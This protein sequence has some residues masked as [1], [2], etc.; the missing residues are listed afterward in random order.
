[1]G[2]KKRRMARQAAAKAQAQGRKTSLLRVAKNDVMKMDVL[3]SSDITGVSYAT[4]TS[5]ASST[6]SS[7]TSWSRKAS[8]STAASSGAA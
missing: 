1:M 7:G 4:V 2:E 6:S 8:G 3:S 5:G